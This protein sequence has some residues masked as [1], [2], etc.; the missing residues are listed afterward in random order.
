MAFCIF[1]IILRLLVRGKDA[2]GQEKCVNVYATESDEF[3]LLEKCVGD[4]EPPYPSGVVDEICWLCFP[5]GETD[6]AN[7]NIFYRT[8]S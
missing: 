4:L 2:A 5:V 6:L 3:V 8:Y 1:F 7:V